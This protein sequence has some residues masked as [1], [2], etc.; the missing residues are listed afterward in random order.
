MSGTWPDVLSNIE[1]SPRWLQ[2]I[3]LGSSTLS[4]DDA[5]QQQ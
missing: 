4:H 5:L 3:S 1:R 2:S